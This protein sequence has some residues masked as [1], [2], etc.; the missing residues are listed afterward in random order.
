ME[1]SV[2]DY[3]RQLE[4]I[5]KNER[6][7]VRDNGAILRHPQKNKR[8][9]KYDNF[10]TF[11]TLNNYG[12]LLIVSE[13]VHRIV[14]FA[15]LGEPPT[16]NHIVDHID[17]NRQNNRPEN[18]RWITK[19]ENILNNPITYKKI[20]FHCGSIEAF[21][22]DPSILKKHEDAD[23]NFSWMKT[24]TPE[25]AKKS[26]ERL[27]DWA[28]KDSKI[29]KSH[30][31]SK[32]EWLFDDPNSHEKFQNQDKITQSL[33]PNAVQYE[34]KTPCEFP[35]CPI[36]ISK[37]PIPTYKDNL[38]EGKIFSKNIYS[39]SIIIDFDISEDNQILWVSCK[40]TNESEIKPWTLVKITFENNLF[41]HSSLGTYFKKEGVEKAFA[42]AR[43]IEWTGG[44]TFDDFV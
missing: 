6:Y 31:I 13:V 44:E 8:I 36:E 10:W 30:Y 9:R 22:E 3:T 16:S 7:S 5:Y 34:W 28:K 11:G 37:N 19:L 21:L 39:E 20:I 35:L 18:L 41:V 15:F 2:D 32:D 25:E 33:T 42:L 4:C 12:Y 29:S 17:T 1:I 38:F 40:K 24:V 43:G 26:W 23:R 14:A 27:L